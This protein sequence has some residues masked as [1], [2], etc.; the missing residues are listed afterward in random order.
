MLKY[1][2]KVMEVKEVTKRNIGKMIIRYGCHEGVKEKPGLHRLLHAC[3]DFLQTEPEE[4]WMN[5]SI[6]IYDEDDNMY[7]ITRG[8]IKHQFICRMRN[9]EPFMKEKNPN[10]DTKNIKKKNTRANS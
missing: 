4:I 10:S 7:K 5:A 3:I 2:D 8:K 6:T 1:Q 9:G